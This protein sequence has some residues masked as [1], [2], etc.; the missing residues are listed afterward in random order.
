MSNDPVWIDQVLNGGA[1]VTGALALALYA[2]CS[3]YAV[4]KELDAQS[5]C[6]AD[7]PRTAGPVTPVAG[8]HV[9]AEVTPVEGPWSVRTKWTYPEG[10]PSFG[11][12][13]APTTGYLTDDDGDGRVGTGDSPVV[14]AVVRDE[15]YDGEL[16]VLDGATGSVRWEVDDGITGVGG[17]AIADLDADGFPEV[18]AI[19]GD[20]WNVTAY[21]GD[22]SVLW[23]SPVECE[24]CITP[25]VADLDGDGIPEVL[26]ADLV[27]G[28]LDGEVLAEVP[29][30]TFFDGET[31]ADLD[32]DGVPSLL[33]DGTA[34]APGGT[35]LWSITDGAFPT[36]FPV[37]VQADD[38]AAAE[39]AWIGDGYVLTQD[40]GD[41]ILSWP[42]SAAG[43]GVPCAGDVDGDGITEIVAPNG[44]QLTLLG[45]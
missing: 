41:E 30:R 37:V 10:D 33:I 42:L 1:A 29:T 16:V 14:V 8:C 44:T 27:L 26:A 17:T 12:A 25:T 31:V 6:Q 15:H 4:N 43:Y 21:R 32:L 22:G 38:D 3:D 39:V 2:G 19:A 35:V 36:F 23:E 28:G 5:P 45:A 9:Q 34:Y 40:D 13:V 11:S 20:G 24:G 7:D 18:V